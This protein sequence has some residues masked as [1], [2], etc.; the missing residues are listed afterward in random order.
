MRAEVQ[1]GAWNGGQKVVTQ[2][3][4][5]RVVVVTEGRFTRAWRPPSPPPSRQTDLEA[6]QRGQAG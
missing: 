1:V 3:G 6:Y 5:G 4:G 2:G